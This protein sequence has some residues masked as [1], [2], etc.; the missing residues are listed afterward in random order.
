MKALLEVLIVFCGL[1]FMSCSERA[2]LIETEPPASEI[3][4]FQSELKLHFDKPVSI[5]R[6]NNVAAK[7]I[8]N[9][10]T[11]DWKMSLRQVEAIWLTAGDYPAQEVC[12]VINYTDE[13]GTHKHDL[14]NWLPGIVVETPIPQIIESSVEDG[15]IGVDPDLLNTSGITFRFSDDVAGS[16]EIRKEGGTSLGWIARW[17]KGNKGDSLTIVPPAGKE[18]VNE[19]TYVIEIYFTDAAGNKIYES[20]TFTTKP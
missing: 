2:H 7:P 12:L 9:P 18:L 16:Y 6:V 13:S 8:R 3:E 17:N 14:C 4:Y 19:T 11:T 10:P 15:D 5:V 20:I 1:V